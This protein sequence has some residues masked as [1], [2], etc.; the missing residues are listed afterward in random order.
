MGNCL[1]C[2]KVLESRTANFCSG[3]EARKYKA[4]L[5]KKYRD[6]GCEQA[7]AE[8]IRF[9]WLTIEGTVHELT[10][11]RVSELLFNGR[12]FGVEMEC[13]MPLSEH[14]SMAIAM[15]E[16]NIQYLAEGY[17]HTVKS[18]WKEVT[19]SSIRIPE[20][21]QHA[22]REVVSPVLK[23]IE[24][25]TQLENVAETLTGKGV[26]VNKSCGLHVH[27]G[28][29]DLTDA[30]IVKAFKIYQYHESVFDS[31]LPNSRRADNNP[32]CGSLS[33]FYLQ[34]CSTP[35]DIKRVLRTRYLKLN[36]ESYFK[37]KTI[38]FR[39]HSGTVNKTKITN[40][41]K[42]CMGVIDWARSNRPY[43]ASFFDD[44]PFFSDELKEYILERASA[45]G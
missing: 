37:Y 11:Q 9:R 15:R 4:D 32:Y 29:A 24:G 6:E 31:M 25:L 12:T 30:Q 41:V 16:N 20:G 8:L 27:I 44:N 35:S 7:K 43:D 13:Y 40:W 5:M 1:Y 10:T 18:Y 14:S 45:L 23:G 33:R 26:R 39:H 34:N 21:S 3:A 36:I 17:N 19:D 2:G 28:V 38:E 22:G 42:I